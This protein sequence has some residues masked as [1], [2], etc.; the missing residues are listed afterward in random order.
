MTIITPKIIPT[1]APNHGICWSA[2]KNNNNNNNINKSHF[3]KQKTPE[4]IIKLAPFVFYQRPRSPKQRLSNVRVVRLQ[5]KC[6]LV[7]LYGFGEAKCLRLN[8]RFSEVALQEKINKKIGETAK[9]HWSPQYRPFVAPWSNRAS[10]EW[11]SARPPWHSDTVAISERRRIC[12]CTANNSAGPISSRACNET[13]PPRI[14][15]VLHSHCP[16]PCSEV[17]VINRKHDDNI[18]QVVYMCVMKEYIIEFQVPINEIMQ[19]IIN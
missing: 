12:C 11:S 16:P 7:W 18:I 5:G 6:P 2:A 19:I 17:P 10:G 9:F 13:S 8:F 4:K 3:Q 15:P 1:P 14:F